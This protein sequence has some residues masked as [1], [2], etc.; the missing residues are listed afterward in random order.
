MREA[1]GKLAE[2]KALRKISHLEE[3]EELKKLDL[4]VVRNRVAQE[5]PDS[6]D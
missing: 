2:S 1:I 3:E 5:T 4:A 6:S